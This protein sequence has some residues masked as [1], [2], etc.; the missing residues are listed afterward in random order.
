[1]RKNPLPSLLAM[2]VLATASFSLG[3]KDLGLHGN[4]YEIKEKNLLDIIREE[5]KKITPERMK[6]ALAESIEEH[7]TVSSELSSCLVTKDR[8][9]NPSVVL[10]WDIDLSEY[11]V[12][13]PKGTMFNPL[14]EALYP[15]Y[16]LFI[17]ASNKDHIFLAQQLQKQTHG[18]M[19][20]VVAKGNM[21]D[22][23]AISEEIYK[24]DRAVQNALKPNCLPS[25][26]VQQGE[27]FL[28]REFAL[29]KKDGK[30]ESNLIGGEQ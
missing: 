26:Y 6:E 17:D 21:M 5:S 3:F 15:G 16:I 24:H 10:D 9:M 30:D 4:L 14:R 27:E 12:F 29:Q 8:M 28:V 19:I 20:T 18:A 23:R 11:G 7:F 2:A 13:I 22:A 25:V 1:M